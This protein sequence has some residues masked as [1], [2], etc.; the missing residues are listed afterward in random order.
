[1]ETRELQRAQRRLQEALRAARSIRTGVVIRYDLAEVLV[2]VLKDVLAERA[3]R[4]I[5]G[6]AHGS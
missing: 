3:A 1:M 2:N 4:Q 6:G 5:S